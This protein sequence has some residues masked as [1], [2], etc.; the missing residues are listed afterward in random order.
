MHAETSILWG[1]TAVRLMIE[2]E[3]GEEDR[4][5]TTEKKV[6]DAQSM[7]PQ[8]IHILQ[9]PVPSL[10]E[11]CIVV[12]VQSCHEDLTRYL[13]RI[14]DQRALIPIGKRRRDAM[15]NNSEV[16]AGDGVINL[17]AVGE[18]LRNRGAV[19]MR[20]EGRVGPFEYNGDIT[21]AK[22][23]DIRNHTGIM[24]DLQAA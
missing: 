12:C 3:A 10:P 20:L 13:P 2:R 21:G 1:G 7:E 15:Q 14:V 19:R 5:D 18:E 24:N 8:S 23:L 16:V 22:V 4:Y 11:A 17:G 9:K 6:L